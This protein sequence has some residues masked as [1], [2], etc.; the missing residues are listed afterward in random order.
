MQI[1]PYGFDNVGLG[2]VSLDTAILSPQAVANVAS[3]YFMHGIFGLSNDPPNLGGIPSKVRTET[4]LNATLA[5][6]QSFG[7]LP[8]NSFSY[9]AGSVGRNSA[10]NLVFGGYDTSRVSPG[11]TLQVDIR[12]IT[13][14]SS[15]PLSVKL[16]SITFS[17]STEKWR[18][19][20]FDN[21]SI[22]SQSIGIDSTMPQIWLPTSACAV[23]EAVFERIFGLDWDDT[24]QLYLINSTTHD[25][26]LEVN[27]SVTFSLSSTRHGD[28]VVD[29]ELPYSAFD[30]NVSYPLVEEQT[31][32]FPLKRASKQDRYVLGR[33]F[34]QETH[35]SVDYDSGYFNLLRALPSNNNPKLETILASTK[36]SDTSAP[37]TAEAA[38]L[39]PGE[40]AGIGSGVCIAALIM[41]VV[42]LAWKKRWWFF[43]V[44]KHTANQDRYDKA[45]LHDDAIQRV[46]AM[47]K[48]RFELQ[49]HERT[50]EVDGEGD[51]QSTV[52]GLNELH[53]VHGE[54]VR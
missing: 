19:E 8:S 54:C 9:T 45:E 31:Y 43:A 16:S 34:L 52:Q 22:Y 28:A 25:R 23:F 38:G 2:P 18:P 37:R 14:P 51:V 44:R 50:C 26:L 15:F 35:V 7:F 13:T 6:I 4:A 24:A 41:V 12:N 39:P 48:E 42:L 3:R 5:T 27:Q 17:V 11:S 36:P 29:F 33:A 32:Y 49:V 40:Y 53:E 20:G 47:A 10:P 1:Q 46:E 21:P 30:L